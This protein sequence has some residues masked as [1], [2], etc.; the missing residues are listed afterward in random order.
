MPKLL[1]IKFDPRGAYLENTGIDESD[2]R[3]LDSKLETVRNEILHEDLGLFAGA[4]A[5]PDEK[6]PLDAGFLELPERILDAY[7]TDRETSELNQ[8]LSTA[9]R[10]R[11]S[12]D[13]VVVLGIGGSYMGARALM[14]SC[15]EP[16]FNEL[17]PEARGGRP[18]MYF[19]GYNVDNDSTQGLL[20]LL[21]NSSKDERWAMIV[22][23]K[24][25]GTLETAGAL[26]QFINA[27]VES[28]GREHLAEHLI[29]VTGATGKLASLADSIGCKDRFIVPDGVGG[30]FS[31]LSPVGLLPAAVLGINVVQLLEAASAMNEHFRQTPPGENVVLDYVAVNH[32]LETQQGC[33]TRIL[34]AWNNSLES[35]GLWYDQLLAESLGKAE[36]G[37]L[38]L[39]V[40]NTRDLHSR[41]QQHQEGRRDKVVNNLIVENWRFDPLPIG[42]TGWNEDLLDEISDKTLPDVMTAAIRG[43]NKAYRDDGRPTTDI[44]LPGANEASLGQFLQMMMLATVV[45]GRLLNINP[46][47]QPGVENYKINMNLFLRDGVNS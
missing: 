45:E 32:L 43:T 15:C 33:N 39:T 29:P 1:P 23:S 26:R 34:S 31:I 10:L 6:C 18:R 25:G 22:I 27:F 7:Q 19:A 3:A 2:V 5:I 40:V 16:Y 44:I 46:Y 9:K 47:G 13:R 17:P 42:T 14:E 20:Q 35:I 8:I 41:A 36:L 21:R 24:S 30:R 37:A 28:F 11:E 38:P 4:E 12:V